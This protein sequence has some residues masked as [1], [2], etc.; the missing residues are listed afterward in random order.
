[1]CQRTGLCSGLYAWD[2]PK[3][4]IYLVK[5]DFV[6]GQ[7]YWTALDCTGVPNKVATECMM[8]HNYINQTF[9]P[10]Y[11]G[12]A[13]GSGTSVVMDQPSDV[14][15]NPEEEMVSES[16]DDEPLQDMSLFTIY[17]ACCGETQSNTEQQEGTYIK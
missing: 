17:P 10:S 3:F 5:V 9:N 15:W 8:L 11:P 13:P 7:F 12:P 2:T 14:W 1:M 16:V 6:A 4:T